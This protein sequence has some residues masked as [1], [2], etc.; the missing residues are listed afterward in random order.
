MTALSQQQVVQQM[1][2]RGDHMTGDSAQ[3]LAKEYETTEE[4]TKKQRKIGRV[5]KRLAASGHRVQ[6]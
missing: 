6:V 3:W 5:N 4:P 1:A 2:R